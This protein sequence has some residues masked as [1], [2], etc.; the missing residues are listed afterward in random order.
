MKRGL[1]R[2]KIIQ[3]LEATARLSLLLRIEE[4]SMAL[5]QRCEMTSN[6][7]DLLLMENRLK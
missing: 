1:S 7:Q 4:G 2:S 3:Q 5:E 6:T